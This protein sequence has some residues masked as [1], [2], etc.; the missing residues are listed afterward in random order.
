VACDLDFPFWLKPVKSVCSHLGFCIGSQEEFE[1]SLSIIRK[2]IHRFAGPFNIFM[3]MADLPEWI[4]GVD[5]NHC[6]AESL[7]SQGHQCTLEG[8]VLGDHVHVYGA[9]DS[10][11]DEDHPSCFTRYQ[12][13]STLPADVLERMERA[14]VRVMEHLGYKDSPFNIEFYWAEVDDAIRLLEINTRI[15]KSHCP[16]FRMVDGESNHAV[17]IDVALGEEPAFP[18]RQGSF[19]L[20]AKFMLRS[21]EDGLVLQVPGPGD[22]RKLTNRFP[23]AQLLVQVRP[24]QILSSLRE[25]DSY[26][27]EFAVLY[28]GADSEDELI[29][30]YRQARSI[31]PFAIETKEGG[32]AHCP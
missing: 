18:C 15:S 16:L 31:L 14:T 13:P 26:S 11:R 21:F 1:N 3:A 10:I 28:L 8:Y 17:M 27:Y 5:G 22:V 23:E 24:G 25:Q 4:Q 20:A 2:K 6:I 32:H 9:V 19:A 7:I 12:Y 29:Q 30:K